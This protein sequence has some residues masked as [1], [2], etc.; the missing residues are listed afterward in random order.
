MLMN[1]SL[2]SLHTQM[3]RLICYNCC[4]HPTDLTIYARTPSYGQRQVARSY[5]CKLCHT[6]L[7][8]D[9]AYF[10]HYS[11]QKSPSLTGLNGDIN[12]RANPL[13][14]PRR[15]NPNCS[16][17]RR[18]LEALKCIKDVPVINRTLLVDNLAALTYNQSVTMPEFGQGH[19]KT[20]KQTEINTVPDLEM[21]SQDPIE[22][23]LTIETFL[24]K[25]TSFVE[26]VQP[27]EEVAIR[28]LLR[29]VGPNMTH[30]VE[31]FLRKWDTVA[32][33]NPPY[34]L[35]CAFLEQIYMCAATPRMA[36]MQ[37]QDLRPNPGETP[38]DLLNRINRLANLATKEYAYELQCHY[39]EELAFNAFLTALP[40]KCQRLLMNEQTLRLKLNQDPLGSTAALHFLQQRIST[41][42]VVSS[43]GKLTYRAM[44]GQTYDNHRP[45][46]TP[47]RPGQFV[48]APQGRKAPQARQRVQALPGPPKPGG[49]NPGGGGEGGAKIS[50]KDLC[51]KAKV[52]AGQCLKC[53]HNN[54]KYKD[55]KTFPGRLPKQICKFHKKY[56]HWNNKCPLNPEADLQ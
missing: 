39:A 8:R 9:A 44:V 48:P 25:M 47:A 49:A 10:E 31:Q 30:T 6:Q 38:G 27:K 3:Y 14:T 46:G 43:E 16:R 35:P 33:G 7:A 50:Y 45:T 54:H 15:Y 42:T 32:I 13:N 21:K 19:N 36:K 2:T 18:K 5:T 17:D 22:S 1:S 26:T 53:G 29:K 37:L 24:N 34:F 55:C 11:M 40:A 52:S 23:A 20:P 28:V 12:A 41:D 56:L 4:K 51:K